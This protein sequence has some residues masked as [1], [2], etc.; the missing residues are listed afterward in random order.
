MA[1][2]ELQAPL[3]EDHTLTVQLPPTVKPG[4]QVVVRLTQLESASTLERPLLD[5]PLH[6]IG[7]WPDDLS[8]QREDMYGDEGR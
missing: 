5:L 6:H 3:T 8:L 2:I 4:D 1:T 7:P